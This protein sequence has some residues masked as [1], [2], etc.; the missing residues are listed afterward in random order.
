MDQVANTVAKFHEDGFMLMW[1]DNLL[2][3]F[4]ISLRGIVSVCSRSRSVRASYSAILLMSLVS[5]MELFVMVEML[6]SIIL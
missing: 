6:Y 1:G 3:G 4:W 2:T 5:S